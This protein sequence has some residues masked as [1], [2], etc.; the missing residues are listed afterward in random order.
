MTLHHLVYVWEEHAPHLGGI[1]QSRRAGA[2][3]RKSVEG[4]RDPVDE[5]T[6]LGVIVVLDYGIG[7][8]G[9]AYRALRAVG[10]DARIVHHPDEAVD[11]RESCFPESATSAPVPTR[12]AGAV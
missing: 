7:N 1:V 5:G 12:F 9:S 11:A 4:S 6:A 8:L 10:R 3:R 2:S